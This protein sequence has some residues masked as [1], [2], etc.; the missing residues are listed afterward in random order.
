MYLTVAS[1]FV[2]VVF[3]FPAESSDVLVDVA[4]H[5]R[6]AGSTAASPGSRIIGNVSLLRVFHETGSGHPVLRQVR[7]AGPDQ[8]W[9]CWVGARIVSARQGRE[10]YSVCR[11]GQDAGWDLGGDL[12]SWCWPRG[13]R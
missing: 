6:L 1:L 3:Y 4:R 10:Y 5:V 9:G 11:Q 8:R 12:S 7:S 2:L 13:N